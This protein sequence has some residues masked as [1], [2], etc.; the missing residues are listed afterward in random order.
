MQGVILV[1]VLVLLGLI[2]ETASSHVNLLQYSGED[3]C[4][5]EFGTSS[6]PSVPLITLCAYAQQGYVFGCIGLCMYVCI[7]VCIYVDKK[8]GLPL[9]IS[10]L[11]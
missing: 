7:I 9:E 10:P 11:V 5:L 3:Y 2:V 4:M 8:T 6:R 1:V